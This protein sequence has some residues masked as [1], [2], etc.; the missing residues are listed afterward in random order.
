MPTS[1][2]F[3]KIQFDLSV[4]NSAARA[5][6]SPEAPFLLAVLGDFTGRANRGV[7][8][9]VASRRSIPI[10]CDNF[11]R[12]MARLGTTLRLPAPRGSGA[13]ID[14]RFETMEDFHPDNLLKQAGPLA[15]LLQARK[16]L[17]NPATA[18]G[19]IGEV[20]S[21]LVPAPASASTAPPLPASGESAQETL[22]RLMGG[23]PPPASASA[24]SASAG[25]DINTL[26]KN[27]AAPS[28]VPGATPEQ[29]AALAAVD[30]ELAAQLRAILHHP[31]FQS[32]EA[33]WRGL[34]LL[35]R[36]HGAEE[37]LKL[38]LLDVSQQELAAD[39]RAQENLQQTDLFKSLRDQA[40]AVL[41]GAYTFSDAV[42]DIELLGRIAKISAMLGAPFL[43]GASPHFV[44]CDSLALHPD[45]DDWTRAMS[46][47]SRE[48]WAALCALP[49]AAHLGLALPRVLLRQPYGKGSDPVEAFPFEELPGYASHES[50]LW[51]NGAFVCAFL[52]ADAFRAEGW[53]L[54]ASG[55]GELADLPVHKFTQDGE[56][57][58]KPCAEVWLTER[59]GERILGQGLMPLL[60]IKGRG[61]VRLA[62]MQSVAQPA[63]PLSLRCL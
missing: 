46:A 10:D 44:G 48:A 2:S 34:E 33:T 57:Q 21:L 4:G 24:K 53:D 62:N 63:R 56:T 52:L 1:F 45:P 59:A 49:E 11:E 16:R 55:S 43:A 8:E 37:N 18:S 7:M 47:G 22:A 58:V 41:A 54:T 23:T 61:A 32:I 26:I 39:L 36:E 40:W 29:S 50:Y 42:E 35:V 6:R 20:Q 51:G 13:S 25:I 3:G 14:L 27:I 17:Q 38:S 31:A 28:V 30:V 15:A 9:P 19:A 5:P 60:S 12:V